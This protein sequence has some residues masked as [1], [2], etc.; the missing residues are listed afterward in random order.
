MRDS[1]VVKVT[2]LRSMLQDIRRSG[3]DYVKV[4]ICDSDEE[5]PASLSFSACR[6]SDTDTWIDFEDV[7][8]VQN[9]AELLEKCDSAIHMSD[10]LF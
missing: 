5:F 2:E 9:E 8:A 1:V 3:S 6:A 4:S 7:D 10:N